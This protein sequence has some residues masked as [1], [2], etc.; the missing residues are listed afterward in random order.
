[1]MHF[2]ELTCKVDAIYYATSSAI[3]GVFADGNSRETILSESNVKLN[4][5]YFSERLLYS[6]GNDLISVKLDG[7][8]PNTIVSGISL[9]R[10]AVDA[11]S[12]KVYYITSLFRNIHS[13][14]I[15]TGN[16]NNLNITLGDVVDLDTYPKNRY[17]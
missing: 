4:Y 5:D 17:L 1:M 16:E 2:T 7:S 14:D 9:L 3:K 10:F 15:N 11:M 8:D 6:D 12:R 13:I